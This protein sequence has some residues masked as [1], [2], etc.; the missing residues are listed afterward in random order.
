LAPTSRARD[1]VR[2]S[3]ALFEAPYTVCPALPWIATAL[4]MFTMRP[5]FS[6]SMPRI[7]ACEHRNAPFT[8]VVIV[9]S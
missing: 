1:F 5:H 4:D 7:A 6:R 8:F 2:P 9:L 3:R